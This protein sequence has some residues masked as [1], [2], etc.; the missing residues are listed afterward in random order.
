MLIHKCSVHLKTCS[1]SFDVYSTGAILCRAD[2]NASSS[3]MRDAVRPSTDNGKDCCPSRW[4]RSCRM[5]P[6]RTSSG[7][8]QYLQALSIRIMLWPFQDSSR[9]S[10]SRRLCVLGFR[11]PGLCLYRSL[12]VVDSPRHLIH[13]DQKVNFLLTR[14][15]QELPDRDTWQLHIEQ[16]LHATRHL[17]GKEVRTYSSPSYSRISW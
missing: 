12:D 13:Y 1:V 11:L 7:A 6:V 8:A 5:T 15:V 10:C 17:Y 14:R 9:H 3:S 2:I 4:Q 16:G